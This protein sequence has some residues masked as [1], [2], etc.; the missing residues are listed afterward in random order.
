MEVEC[1]VA[2]APSSRALV[3]GVCDLIRLALDAW[4]HDVIL[5]DGTVVDCDV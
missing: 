4:L 3:G 1:V 2:S 5:A